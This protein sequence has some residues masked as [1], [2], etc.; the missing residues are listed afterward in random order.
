M[1]GYQSILSGLALLAVCSFAL[2]AGLLVVTIDAAPVEKT[3][4]TD[5]QPATEALKLGKPVSEHL[6]VT[7]IAGTERTFGDLRGKIVVV[8]F[9]SDSC[10]YLRLAEPKLKKLH[11]DYAVKGVEFIAMASNQAEIAD[12]AAGYARIKAHLK[13]NEVKFDVYPDHGARI[14]DLFGARTTPHC[15]VIDQRGIL[16]YDGALDDDPRGA[17]GAEAKN[18]V[19]AAIDDLTEGRE[20]RV[21]ST[22][23][24]G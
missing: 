3:A 14:A 16:R 12:K 7:D 22:K 15:Y 21:T 10:P 19:R 6:A 2:F 13:K 20:V 5:T 8:A 23:P 1:R 11:A 18:F 9:W 24:Y 17:K 4:L